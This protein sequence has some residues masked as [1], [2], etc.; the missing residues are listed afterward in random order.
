MAISKTSQAYNSEVVGFV[1]TYGSGSG[2]T[3]GQ[4]Y[5]QQV[6]RNYSCTVSTSTALSKMDAATNWMRNNYSGLKLVLTGTTGS[7][8]LVTF[9]DPT[10]QNGLVSRIF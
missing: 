9:T 4:V 3:T 7:V 2:G 8:M 5:S 1:R 10:P 6:Q